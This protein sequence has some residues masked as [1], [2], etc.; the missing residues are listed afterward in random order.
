[1]ERERDELLEE[2]IA[3]RDKVIAYDLDR[4]GIEER[5]KLDAELVE[6]RAA[7]R[8]A[9]A[10][11]SHLRARVVGAEVAYEAQL[12]EIG[13]AIGSEILNAHG[14]VHYEAV[15]AIKAERDELAQIV[16]VNAEQIRGLQD[17]VISAETRVA[18]L[19]QALATAT[20]LSTPDYAT[21]RSDAEGDM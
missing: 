6:C 7:L 14:G 13:R 10:R 2:V 1:M 4:E 5:R 17:Q 18:E 21:A 11:E 16:R 20:R 8:D 19:E 3:M 12:S 15:S 9:V